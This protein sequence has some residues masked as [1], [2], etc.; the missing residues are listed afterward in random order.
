M[1][2]LL[3]FIFSVLS[4][5]YNPIIKKNIAK[6][7]NNKILLSLVFGG[8]YLIKLIIMFIMM[9]M[10]VYVLLVL[11]LGITAG[12]IIFDHWGNAISR[13]IRIY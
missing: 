7:S 1:A 5:G 4:T 9:A 10:N 12:Y 2:L 13:K 6:K 3:T 8:E 11:A